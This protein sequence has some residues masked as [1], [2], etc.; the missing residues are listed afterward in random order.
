MPSYAEFLQEI[1]SKKRRIDEHETAALGEEYSVVVLNQLPAKF[2][3]RNSFCIP[4][5]IGSVSIDRALC[6]LGSSVISRD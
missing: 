5:M 2:I 3:D 1:L 4:Y 6:D